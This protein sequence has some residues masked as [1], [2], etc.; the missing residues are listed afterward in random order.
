LL[1]PLQILGGFQAAAHISFETV[2]PKN[3]PVILLVL[4][5]F[6]HYNFVF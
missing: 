5:I 2:S 4:L 6:F 3:T 1:K